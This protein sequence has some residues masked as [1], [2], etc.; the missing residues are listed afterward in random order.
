MFSR[1]LL[2]WERACRILLA[3]AAVLFLL[4]AADYGDS[5]DER[6]RSDAGE[7][8]L[9]YYTAL[10]SGD[11]Q[12]AREIGMA[13]DHYPG[14]HDLNLAL[15]RRISPLDDHLT[16][17]LFGAVLGLLTFAGAMALAGRL[18][19]ARSAFLAGLLLLF[20]PRFYGH[21]FI[22]PKDIPF[23]FGY[24]WALLFIS[25]WLGS[26]RPPPWRMTLLTGLFIGI[27]MATRIGGLVLLCYLALFIAIDVVAPS[28]QKKGNRRI[29]GGVRRA[30]GFLPKLAAATGIAFIL[31]FLHWPHGQ[32][33]PLQSTGGTMETVTHFSW[34]MPVFFDGAFH[35]ADELPWTY[36]PRLFLLTTPVHFLL[37]GVLGL[38]M[39][40]RRLARVKRDPVSRSPVSMGV[41]LVLFSVLFPPLYILA[42]DS[43]VYNG[44]RHLLFILPPAAV[45]AGLAMSRLMEWSRARQ[46]RLAIPLCSV[47]AVALLMTGRQMIRLHPY[48]YIYYNMLAGGTRNA[49]QNYETD[50]W[51]TAF[52]ELALEFH[53]HLKETRPELSRPMVVVNME[54]VTWLFEPFLPESD[55]LPI[56]VVRSRPDIDDYYAASTLWSADT[57]HEGVVVVT[58][59][60]AGVPLAVVKD[61]R[62]LPP[63]ERPE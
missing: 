53:A 42:R 14:F 48:Q 45:L 49:A 58:V 36:L 2:S 13:R 55:S 33:Q 61:R 5:W 51:G 50:Y 57:F 35:K 15:L 20:L 37:I 30:A 28:L 38:C 62:H 47:L 18:G 40:V 21:C 9:A 19:G 32:W 23:A 27:T 17:N 39:L 54:Q 29:K 4:T 3:C 34:P 63:E 7:K 59:G 22:N 25:G 11:M 60:R 8:K 6:I 56:H 16:G 43:V 44:T 1:D 12:T 24:V 26:G 10:L 52:K 46:P 31:L 41:L